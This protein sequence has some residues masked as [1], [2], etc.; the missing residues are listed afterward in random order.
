MNRTG[1]ARALALV[2]AVV[3]AMWT[4]DASV[5]SLTLLYNA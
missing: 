1:L 5:L 3:A 2:A 4:Y